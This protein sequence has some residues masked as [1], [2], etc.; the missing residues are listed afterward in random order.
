MADNSSRSS[1]KKTY[2]SFLS[3]LKGLDQFG[4]P[5]GL[6]IDGEGEFKTVYG[7]AA[8]VGIGIYLIRIFVVSFIPVIL[9]EIDTSQTQLI[10]FDVDNE[11][12]DP[13]AHG[14]TFA[15]GFP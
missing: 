11:S 2:H 1:F 10:N 8:S 14:F 9:R 13:F 7:G 4:K 3:F 12:F 6:T 15:V 5:V